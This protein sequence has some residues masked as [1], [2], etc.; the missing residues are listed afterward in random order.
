MPNTRNS[1]YAPPLDAPLPAV[2]LRARECSQNQ[3]DHQVRSIPTALA[4]QDW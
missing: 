3:M 2:M 1:G 4:I